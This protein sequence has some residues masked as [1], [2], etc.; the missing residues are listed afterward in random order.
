MVI[1]DSSESEYRSAFEDFSHKAQRVQILM[2]HPGGDQEALEAALLELEKAHIAY[3]QARDAFVESLLPARISTPS[4]Y[5]HDHS[6]DIRTIAQLLWEG[7][8]RPTGTAED[9]WRRAEAI[10]QSATSSLAAA[11]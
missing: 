1:T 2:E 6:R 4:D 5:L 3:D 10:V 9:D 11:C 8:G 7:A